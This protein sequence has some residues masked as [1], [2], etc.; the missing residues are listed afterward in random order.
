MNSR[1]FCSRIFRIF[2]SPNAYA[3]RTPSRS[4]V[5]VVELRKT[6]QSFCGPPARLT[7]Q[8]VPEHLLQQT[9]HATGGFSEFNGLP[10][11]RPLLSVVDYEAVLMSS[12]G[13]GPPSIFSPRRDLL[14]EEL[15]RSRRG[16]KMLPLRLPA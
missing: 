2:F 8:R 5:T 13:S 16:E 11:V 7:V 14:P 3:P 10:R 9:A 12:D 15:R 1:R 6:H 4:C